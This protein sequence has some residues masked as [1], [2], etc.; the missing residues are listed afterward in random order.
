M[1]G[2]VGRRSPSPWVWTAA[3]ALVSAQDHAVPRGGGGGGPLQL[4]SIIPA[5]ARPAARPGLKARPPRPRRGG[6]GSDSSTPQT[7]AQRRHPRPGTGTGDRR[8][9]QLPLRIVTHYGGDPYY[10]CAPT[11]RRA[12]LLAARSYG[13]SPSYQRLPLT[14]SGSLRVIVDPVKTRVYVDGHYAGIADDFGTASSRGSPLPPGRHEI[15]PKLD[16][17]R[18]HKV[19]ACTCRRT[20]R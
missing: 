19:P 12:V 20:R 4:G 13:Y 8:P 3:P 1:K 7:D 6:S 9:Q 16:G 5:V 10:Y 15:S 17:Y 18:T 14:T 2:R 11:R